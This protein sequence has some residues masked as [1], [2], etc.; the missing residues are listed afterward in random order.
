MI[1]DIQGLHHVTALAS[2]AARNNAFFTNVLGLRRVKATVNFDAPDVYHL[3]YGDAQ[4]A[5]GTVMTY[6]PFPGMRSGRPGAGE[7]STTAFAIPKGAAT[8]W[9][10]RLAAADV[11]SLSQDTA[12]GEPRILFEGPDGEQLA[13]VERDADFGEPWTGA[14]VPEDVAIR[15]FHSVRLRLADAGATGELLRF[16]GY[17]EVETADGLTRFAVHEGNAADLIEIDAGGNRT[18]ADQGAGSVHHVAFAVADLLTEE[19]V[20]AALVDTGYQVTPVIDRDYFKSIYFR[21]P[22]GVLFEIATNDPGFARDEPNE[23]LGSQLKLPTRHEHLRG[24]LA[25]LLTPLE[26]VAA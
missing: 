12:F 17:R 6:F 13:L 8:F 22:G 26:G 2:D 23:S 18:G 5:P 4:G 1:K 19:R 15:G 10:E 25:T 16:M 14:G 3:Y 20:R 11:Q 21:T 24:K 9:Q 7:V